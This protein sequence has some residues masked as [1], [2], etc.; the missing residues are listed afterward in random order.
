MVLTVALFQAAQQ[1]HSED[2]SELD[3]DYSEETFQTNVFAAFKLI[4]HA[5]PHLHRGS[6]IISSVSIGAYSG[7]VMAEKVDYAA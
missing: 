4:K 6:S 5:V 7:A 3:V 1:G 2:I